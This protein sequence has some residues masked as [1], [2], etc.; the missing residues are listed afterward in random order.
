MKALTPLN[1]KNAPQ[2]NSVDKT[3]TS[4][5][6]AFTASGQAAT[7]AIDLPRFREAFRQVIGDSDLEWWPA[8]GAILKRLPRR[9]PQKQLEQPKVLS[10]EDR[11]YNLEQLEKMKAAIFGGKVVNDGTIPNERKRAEGV[12]REGQ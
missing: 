5:V 10:L 2:A 1:L 11:R 8:P 7:E 12:E 9:P 6:L 4:W 3:A